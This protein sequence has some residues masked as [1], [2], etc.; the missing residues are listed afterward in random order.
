MMAERQERLIIA[1][2]GPAGV[3][4]STVTTALARALGL[5]YVETGA[6]YRAVALLGVR[7]G[8][9]P[10]D[11]PALAR[12][13][14]R[15]DL[16]FRLEGEVNRVFLDGEEI[17]QALRAPEI[18]PLASTVSSLP[19]V[20]SALLD[21]QRRF[22]RTGRGAVAEG[23]D[24]GTVVFPEADFK[25]FLVGEMETRAGRR[26]RQLLASGRTA[27]KAS[28]MQEI[29]DRDRQDSSRAHAPLKAAAEAIVVDTTALDA[30]QVVEALLEL[31]RK[32]R[33][34]GGR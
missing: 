5:T 11:G 15:M 16:T 2:D 22:G 3:G 12:V 29:R 23:R 34:Q 10:H 6:L 4:K 33:E 13:A 30:G 19:E 9:D 21:V 8:L 25:F 27:D 20:R 1:V 18:G 24:I 31:V 14:S 7:A 26:L 28:V 17:T 32:G